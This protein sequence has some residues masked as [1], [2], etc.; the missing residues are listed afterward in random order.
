[1][2]LRTL[3]QWWLLPRVRGELSIRCEGGGVGRVKLGSAHE[4]AVWSHSGGRFSFSLV[5]KWWK[6]VTVGKWVKILL[7]GRISGA[8]EPVRCKE[9]ATCE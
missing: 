5:L 9:T 4:S 7:F 8:Q 6:I 3:Q 1:M 2:A